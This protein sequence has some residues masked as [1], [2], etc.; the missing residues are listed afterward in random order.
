M[1]QFNYVIKD[2]VGLHAR[3]AGNLAKCAKACAS[4]ITVECNGKTADA[5]KIMAVMSLG[6][7]CGMTLAV[8]VEGENEIKDAEII[9]AFFE[10][11]L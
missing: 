10:E 2:E 3:P 8:T 1:V 4:K 7:K 5:T 9:Q 11:N 6:A